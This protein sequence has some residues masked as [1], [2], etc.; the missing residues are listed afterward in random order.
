MVPG[1][2]GPSRSGARFDERVPSRVPARQTIHDN[3]PRAG[4]NAAAHLS[5]ACTPSRPPPRASRRRRVHR[6]S[7]HPPPSDSRPVDVASVRSARSEL[8]T[9]TRRK[10]SPPLSSPSW[11]TTSGPR[12]AT[13]TAW[14][15]PTRTGARSTPSSPSSSRCALPTIEQKRRRHPRGTSGDL[16]RLGGQLQREDRAVRGEGQQVFKPSGDPNGGPGTYTNV[17]ELFGGLL[18]IKLDAAAEVTVATAASGRMRQT[19]SR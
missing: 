4:H 7:V 10:R 19:R 8:P 11:S 17:V 18:A 15:S 12:P 6:A 9:R 14:T 16:H 5:D 3:Y 13:P 2:C 1:A